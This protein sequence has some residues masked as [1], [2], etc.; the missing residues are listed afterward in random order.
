MNQGIQEARYLAV[1]LKA[2]RLSDTLEKVE[3]VISG[4]SVG[5]MFE[6]NQA[7]RDVFGT[8]PDANFANAKAEVI[9][10]I[11]AYKPRDIDAGTIVFEL[12]GI[13]QSPDC[14][15]CPAFPHSLCPP[16]YRYNYGKMPA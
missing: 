6:L 9:R 11:L 4:E 12:G 16:C 3:G 10:R 2:I 1:V 14:C 7:I 8:S 5:A 13:T 15:G